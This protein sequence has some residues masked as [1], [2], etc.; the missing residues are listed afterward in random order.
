MLAFVFG[1][2]AYE[3]FLFSLLQFLQRAF[4][5]S[6]ISGLWS[7]RL[8]AV[9]RASLPEFKSQQQTGLSLLICR[10]GIKTVLTLKA[11]YKASS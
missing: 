8:R 9:F 10:M 1:E 4:I 7:V 11:S 5:T 6:I 3:C 2:W